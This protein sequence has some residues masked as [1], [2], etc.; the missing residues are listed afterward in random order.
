MILQADGKILKT[1]VLNV[2]RMQ[3]AE[4]KAQN[5]GRIPDN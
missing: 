2:V 3:S 1:T 4:V 5:N